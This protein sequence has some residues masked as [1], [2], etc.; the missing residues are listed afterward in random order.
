MPG[1]VDAVERVAD[2]KIARGGGGD[3]GEIGQIPAGVEKVV[4]EK[5]HGER[6]QAVS[7]GQPVG[8]ENG[9]EKAEIGRCGQQHVR[10]PQV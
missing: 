3:D 7:R 10:M 9:R 4:G 6:A 2:Q 1:R 8:E 5:H